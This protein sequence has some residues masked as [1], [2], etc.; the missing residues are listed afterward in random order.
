MITYHRIDSDNYLYFDNLLPMLFKKRFATETDIQ[1]LGASVEGS[2]CGIILYREESELGILRILY[3]AVSKPF[4]GQGIA[5]ELL[6]TLSDAA[7]NS[8]GLP[9]VADFFAHNEDDAPY[10]LF[11]SSG[12]FSVREEDG[13]RV[14][15]SHSDMTDFLKKNKETVAKIPA[16]KSISLGDMDREKKNILF[17]FYSKKAPLGDFF[18]GELDSGLTNA[19]FSKGNIELAVFVT[20]S[21]SPLGYYISYLYSGSGGT[22]VLRI[23]S[24]TMLLIYSRMKKTDSLVFETLTDSVDML[25][26]HLFG[27][28]HISERR[29]MAGYNGP[30][31]I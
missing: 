2:A 6:L 5:T 18:D 11:K 23:I 31:A 12:M 4:Q 21:L 16:I 30:Y 22:D 7:Y 27:D 20:R 1:G 19:V 13:H 26:L 29:F 25:F 9:A 28:D 10:R 15:L 3:I 8:T 24:R 14:V 17:D